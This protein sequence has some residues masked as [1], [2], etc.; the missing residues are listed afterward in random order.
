MNFFDNKIFDQVYRHAKSTIYKQNPDLTVRVIFW[1][2]FG[3]YYE[4]DGFAAKLW[5]GFDGKKNL[6]EIIDHSLGE[7]IA[8]VPKAKFLQDLKKFLVYTCKY[9]LL[10]KLQ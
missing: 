7:E 9:G 8:S 5:C 10:E 3:S 4:I 6:R 1:D 2:K